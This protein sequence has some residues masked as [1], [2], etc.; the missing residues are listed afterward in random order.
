[1][2]III[3]DSENMMTQKTK[4]KSWGLTTLTVLYHAYKYIFQVAQ[5]N[6]D[7]A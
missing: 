1:M 3:Q 2:T 7:R 6:E 5:D 4:T